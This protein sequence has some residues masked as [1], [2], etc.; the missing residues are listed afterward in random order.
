M[1]DSLRQLS[2]AVIKIIKRNLKGIKKKVLERSQDGGFIELSLEENIK[3]I[4][5]D[6]VGHVLIGG[7]ITEVEGIPISKQ[8]DKVT[9][10]Y[11]LSRLTNFWHKITGGLSTKLGLSTQYNRIKRIHNDCL[12]E[13][14]KMVNHRTHSKDYVMCL[15]LVDI[16][17]EYNKKLEAEG[18]TEK[19]L[20]SKEILYNIVMFIF[21]S[22]ETSNSFARNCIYLLGQL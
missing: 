6:V 19:R 1:I 12:K 21:A 13:I 10:G 16:I 8:L 11:F 14:E 20:N 7:E 9:E 18:H 2:P 17:I 15:N 22:V 3:Q 4:T 5:S